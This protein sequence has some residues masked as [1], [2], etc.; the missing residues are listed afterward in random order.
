MGTTPQ[1]ADSKE[2]EGSAKKRPPAAGKGR[3]KGSVNKTTAIVRDAIS[4]LAEGNVERLQDWLDDI[5]ANEKQ[6]PAVAFK[7]YMD[8]LEYHIPKLARTEHTGENGGAVKF[9]V[10]APWLQQQ[11]QKRNS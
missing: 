11:V 1:S 4:R 5:A 6:G 2:I 10:S 8:M 7:L 3:P 9:E